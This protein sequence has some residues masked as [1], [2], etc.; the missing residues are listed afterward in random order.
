VASIGSAATIVRMVSLATEPT[1]STVINASGTNAMAAFG[2]ERARPHDQEHQA[3]ETS[4][5]P[6]RFSLR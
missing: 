6:A 4:S 3:R 5:M 2:G 1:V